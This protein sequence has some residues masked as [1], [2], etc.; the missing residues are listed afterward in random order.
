MTHI[1]VQKLENTNRT[2]QTVLDCNNNATFTVAGNLKIFLYL[3]FTVNDSDA[4]VT[5]K[6]CQ[7]HQ[8]W[9]QL[10]DPSKF[11]IMQSLKDLPY[12]VSAEKKQWYSF[13]QI[14]KQQ[15]SPLSMYE[16]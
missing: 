10:V 16:S 2:K 3:S 13:R 7:G 6:Q 15:S 1:Q 8:A 12:A 14:R 5:L 11:I 4:P 9:Y